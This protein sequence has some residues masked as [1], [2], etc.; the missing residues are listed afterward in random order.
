[1]LVCIIV[2]GCNFLTERRWLVVWCVRAKWRQ[3]WSR[4]ALRRLR[5][6]P[7]IWR[8]QQVQGQKSCIGHFPSYSCLLDLRHGILLMLWTIKFQW[9]TGSI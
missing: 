9:R 7:S 5:I 4:T 8:H 6:A 3:R 2:I 1:M